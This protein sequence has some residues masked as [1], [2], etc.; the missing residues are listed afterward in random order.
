LAHLS[1][2]VVCV[3]FAGTVFHIFFKMVIKY[4]NK[5]LLAK[6]RVA[7]QEG[8][9]EE[10]E[11]LYTEAIKNDPLEVTAYHRLMV[12][13]RRQKD[14]KQEQAIIQAAIAA[15]QRHAQERHQTW[16]QQNKQ[17]ARTARA[18]VKSLGLV[19]KKGIPKVENL[20][21]EAWRKRLQLVRK[22]LER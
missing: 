11:R 9:P 15:H 20:Q 10:A 13:Y 6:A 18:L 17:T 19:D 1:V 4:S 22:R 8:R 21:L 7:E 5:Y 14:Y 12:Y 16:L 2:P 3:L